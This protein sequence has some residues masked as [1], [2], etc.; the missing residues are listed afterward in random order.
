MVTKT[1]PI[2]WGC[3]NIGKWFDIRGMM[4]VD[5]IDDIVSSCNSINENT[6]NEMLP[7]VEENY[8]KAQYL[9]TIGDRLKEEIEKKL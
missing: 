2:Y 3:P 6:Y 9:K 4:I 5:N 1:V 8:N 7:F